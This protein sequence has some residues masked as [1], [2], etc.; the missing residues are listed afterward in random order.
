MQT[1]AQAF[2][3]QAPGPVEVFGLRLEPL[4]VP[5][6]YRL[7]AA[8]VA[9]LQVAVVAAAASQFTQ[10][11]MISLGRSMRAVASVPITAVLER[12]SIAICSVSQEI[13]EN[14]WWTMG[15]L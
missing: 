14:W 13:S 5:G 8:T 2:R 11:R 12:C 4:P 1:E 9:C 15:D 10:A 3:A 7:M 6:P